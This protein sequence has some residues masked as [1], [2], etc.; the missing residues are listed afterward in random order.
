MGRLTFIRNLY[1]RAT[2]TGMPLS[3][4]TEKLS[5]E[6]DPD[7]TRS[8]DY[9][10]DLRRLG[11]QKTEK[12]TSTTTYRTYKR[13]SRGS[14]GRKRAVSGQMTKTA[15]ATTPTASSSPARRA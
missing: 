13:L 3:G 9:D 15:T 10:S 7:N 6:D 12:S 14:R 8:Y 11:Q 2:A 1:A 4:L 5:R